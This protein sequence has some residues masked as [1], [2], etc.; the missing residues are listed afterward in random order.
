MFCFVPSPTLFGMGM[1]NMNMEDFEKELAEANKAIEEYVA[2]LPP[3]EQAEFNKQVEEMSRMFE[4]MS[5]DEFEQFL[6]EMFAD[7]PM[8][9]PNPFDNIQTAQQETAPEV[10]LSAE[11]KKKVE[12]ALAVLD[13]IIKQSN[14]FMVIVN[15]SSDLPGRIDQWAKKGE[16]PH[17]QTGADWTALKLEIEAFIQKL[18]KAE[19]QDLTTKKYKY[20]FE[21]IADEALYNNLIQLRT[22]LK[23]VV[24][25]IDIPEF[26]IKKLSAESK[27]AIKT[28][29]GKYTESFY[30]LDI[31]KTLTTLFEK[32]A[33]E[34]EKIKAAEEAATKRAQEASRMTRTPAAKTE[35][36]S[37][38]YGYDSYSPYGDYYGGYDNYSPYSDYS[39]GYDNYSPYGGY[40]S[41][42]GAGRSG[43]GS[44][45]GGGSS[46]GANGSTTDKEKEDKDKKEED[47]KKKKE[48]HTPNYEIDTL[49]RDIK[50][51]LEEIKSA[52]ST[53]E[54]DEDIKPTKLADLVGHITKDEKID[55]ILTGYVLPRVVDKKLSNIE[56]SLKKLGDKAVRLNADDL[57]HYQREVDKLFTDYKKELNALSEAISS[58]KKK[59]PEEIAAEERAP[60]KALAEG[61]KEIFDITDLPAVKQWAYFG[62]TGGLSDEEKQLANT[63]TPV[64]LFAIGEKITKILGDAKAFMGKKAEAPKMQKQSAF[65]VIP[66]IPAAPDI[67]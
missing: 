16:I 23:K 32:Y 66:A 20:L 15:S 13:D 40:D 27:T 24:P 7:E 12:T 10:V 28:V 42:S 53:Q 47:K 2:S 62:E 64:S 37:E 51:D 29:L 11:D 8:M 1:P 39:G 54:N 9:E 6:G 45:S 38:D 18:Y 63:I 26:S 59:T 56:S 65:D 48:K 5:E 44:G 57:L 30:L 36:G 22:E 55:E 3:A 46:G 34:E 14:I 49:L 21:L 43:G 60:K 67:E 33:P 52:M 50:K 41:G 31:P 25:T 19:E 35:A 4:N 61:E 17:W 58:F